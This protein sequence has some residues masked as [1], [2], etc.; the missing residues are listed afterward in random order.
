MNGYRIVDL[1]L[2]L[3]DGGGFLLPARIT[4]LDHETRGRLVAE[5]AGL[6]PADLGGRANAMEEFS[7]LTSHTGTH[8]DAPWHY[9]NTAAGAPAPTIDQIP[10]DWCMGDGVWLDLDG[11]QPGEDITE[12][13]LRQA[14]E[15]IGYTLRS[16][17]ILLIRTGTARHYGEPGCDRMN[18][19]VT[20][21]AT[22]WL[23]RQ[24][25]RVVGIDSGIWDRPVEMQLGDL[26]KGRNRE[27]Y[28]Q[29][30]RAAGDHGMCILE[31]LTNL[32]RLPHTGFLVCAFPVKIH[33]AG[34]AWVRAVALVKD[35]ETA[36]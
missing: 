24:G 36:P 34:G 27:A 33:R 25:I 12:A 31:W 10:L 20:A 4:Y 23:G 30:H 1:S 2:P 3:L 8:M 16:G 7:F 6:T 11:M 32:E 21:E 18:P 28:M 5:R 26:R 9:G 29:G 19:G 17:D 13:D 22:A 35:P 15:R 14:L